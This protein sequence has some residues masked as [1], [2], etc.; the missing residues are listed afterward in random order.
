M[1]R[2]NGKTKPNL[3]TSK[4]KFRKRNETDLR[5]TDKQKKRPPKKQNQTVQAVSQGE[6]N[7]VGTADESPGPL[8]RGGGGPDHPVGRLGEVGEGFVGRLRTFTNYTRTGR[9]RVLRLP[10]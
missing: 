8:W 9:R 10:S 7:D 1:P 5:Q 4:P 2:E 3:R 6:Q